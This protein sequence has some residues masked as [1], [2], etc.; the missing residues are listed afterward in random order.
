[1]ETAQRNDRS[2]VFFFVVVLVFVF[3]S[4]FCCSNCSDR[5]DQNDHMKTRLI[6]YN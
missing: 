2:T 3:V 1:M 5:N 6:S 4:F